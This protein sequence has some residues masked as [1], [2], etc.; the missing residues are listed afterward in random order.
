MISP[1]SG[2]IFVS[3]ISIVVSLPV[4]ALTVMSDI[5]IC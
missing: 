2:F 3:A 4:I 5:G 1:V